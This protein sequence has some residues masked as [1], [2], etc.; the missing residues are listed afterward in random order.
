VLRQVAALGA[1]AFQTS[2]PTRIGVAIDQITLGGNSVQNLRGDITSNANGWNLDRLEFRAP[3]ATQ[4]RLSGALAVGS[5]GVAFTGPA[6]IDSSDPRALAL[7]LE[8]RSDYTPNEARPLNLRGNVTVA[9]DRIAV[10]DLKADF[11]RKPIT[12]RLAYIFASGKG[13]AK[14]DAELKA[15]QLDIDAAIGFGRALFAGSNF[16][17][18]REMAVS[19]DIGRVAFSGIDARDA[20]IHFNV[21]AG[22]LRVDRF[23]IGDIGGGSLA[24]SGRIDT[25]GNVPRG[26]IMVDLETTKAAEIAAIAEKFASDAFTPAVRLLEQARRAKLH[27]SLDVGGDNASATDGQ[28]A[29]TGNLDDLRIEGHS[30]IRGDWHTRTVSDL[31]L[32]VTADAATAAP[33]I[34]LANLDGVIV[35]G[36]GPAQLRFQLAGPVGGDMTFDL[37][38]AGGSLSARAAGS[39]HL[40]GGAGRKGAAVVQV[41]QAFLRPLVGSGPQSDGTDRLPLQ[42]SARVALAGGVVTADEIQAKLGRSTTHGRLRVEDTTPRRIEGAFDADTGNGGEFIAYLIGLPQ[43]TKSERG[44]AW[45]SEPFGPGLFDR[46]TGK[47]SLHFTRVE[48]PFAVSGRDFSATLEFANEIITVES[49][50]AV[51]GGKFAGLVKFQNG[52]DGLTARA[53]ISLA[54]ADAAGLSSAATRPAVTGSLNLNLEAEGTGLSAVALVGSAKGSGKIELTNARLA[55]LDPRS[56]DATTRAVDQGMAIEPKRIADVVRKSIEAGRLS[57]KHAES[58]LTINAGQVRLDKPIIK[59]DEAAL[60]VA[61]TLDLID[62]LI[63]ARLVLSGSG[64][65]AGARPDIYIALKGP[66][67]DV[68]RTI[69][70]SAL[71]GWLTLRSVENQTKQLRAIELT[72][73]QPTVRPMPK[74]NQA[75]P[76]PA[77]TDIKPAPKPRS[78]GQPAASVRTQN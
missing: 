66:V 68:S 38:I 53:K 4:V 20:N 2:L 23:A 37:Q 17:R 73:P 40:F 13:L 29:V 67:P 62:G 36:S 46:F 11:D 32:K 35:P 65:A 26:S 41:K 70:V 60:S 28:L 19:I 6:Q 52:Q 71:T 75:P 12:G 9:S 55:G 69:D 48:L 39:G 27:A 47:I 78:L 44:S 61:G 16:E 10:E 7:W 21:D 50:G 76:L 31:E 14:L 64:E 33:L 43:M 42:F 72:P 15:P 74:I 51:A 63:D 45:S 34:K 58:A 56:F 59:S 77:P 18:P 5:S 25:K 8:G 57:V 3:G 24:A 49:S 1:S 30:Q 22:G 54:G